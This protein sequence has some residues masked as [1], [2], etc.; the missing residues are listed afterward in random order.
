MLSFVFVVFKL[1]DGGD[2]VSDD[3]CLERLFGFVVLVPLMMLFGDLF[4]KFWV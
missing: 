3:I 1:F 2:C 4:A